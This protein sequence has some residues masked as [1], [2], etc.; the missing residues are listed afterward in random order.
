MSCRQTNTETENDISQ[1]A[2]RHVGI[3]IPWWSTNNDR[4]VKAQMPGVDYRGGW[5][6]R[7]LNEVTMGIECYK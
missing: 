3:T 2:Y 4:H 6:G 5:M 7:Q 1:H